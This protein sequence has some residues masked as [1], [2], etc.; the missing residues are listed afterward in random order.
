M[1][2]F[3]DAA[4]DSINKNGEELCGDKVEIIKEEEGVI[5][6]L[7]DGLGSGVKANI[8][9]GLTTKIAATMLKEGSTIEETIDTIINTLPICKVRGIA[10]STFTIIKLFNDGRV[11]IAEY[12][13]P[14]YFLI[15]KN[16]EVKMIKKESDINGRTVKESHFTMEADDTLVVVSDGVIHAGVGNILNFGW[17]WDNVSEYL[18]SIVF[19]EKCAKNISKGLIDVCQ[20]LYDCRPGDDATVFAIKLREEEVIDLFAGPPENKEVDRWVIEKLVESRGLKVICG[21]TAANIAARE[22]K[23]DIIVDMNVVD[24]NLPPTAN[25]KGI[26]LVTEGVLTLSKA[27]EKLKDYERIGKKERY[28]LYLN[29]QDGASR[30]VKMLI[31]DCTHINFWVGKAKNPAHQNP[32]LP[33]DLSIKLKVLNE[34]ADLM[35]RLGKVVKFTY[36]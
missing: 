14:P 8:L 18:K 36:I 3:I 32:D 30:L 15:S 5:V 29:N 34:I 9:A 4:F 12:E 7:S 13:N 22:L 19:K 23:E 21:G 27:L 35:K 24:H 25:I 10:Y 11:Y 6:V 33:V 16:K 26:D 20:Q 1:R 17:Q 31:E 28:G 2:Y